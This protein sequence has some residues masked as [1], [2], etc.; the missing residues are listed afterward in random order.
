MASKY[1]A[2]HRFASVLAIGGR[3]LSVSLSAQPHDGANPAFAVFANSGVVVAGSLILVVSR[4]VRPQKF[5]EHIR[6]FALVIAG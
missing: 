2:F 4:P 6:E 1:L 5:E 3:S